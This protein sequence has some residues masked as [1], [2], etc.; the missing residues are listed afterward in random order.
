MCIAC[1]LVGAY[2][3]SASRST[4]LPVRLGEA[5]VLQDKTHIRCDSNRKLAFG[6]ARST[7]KSAYSYP[8]AASISGLDAGMDPLG[9]PIF[10]VR[11]TTGGFAAELKA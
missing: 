7:T 6:L 1:D 11:G 8:A 2:R 4:S 9:L 5:I 10:W 3:L